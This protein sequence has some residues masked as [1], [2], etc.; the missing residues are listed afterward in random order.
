MDRAEMQEVAGG[1]CQGPVTQ[2]WA[3]V[4]SGQGGGSP[5]RGVRREASLPAIYEVSLQWRGH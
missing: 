2:P 1:S 3:H 4:V 5:L